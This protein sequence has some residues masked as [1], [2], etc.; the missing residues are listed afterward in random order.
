MTSCKSSRTIL[1]LTNT[2]VPSVNNTSI[3]LLDRS[4]SVMNRK[5]KILGKYIGDDMHTNGLTEQH[6]ITFKDSDEVANYLQ[7]VYL[8]KEEKKTT[9]LNLNLSRL[10]IA[11]TYSTMLSKALRHLDFKALNYLNLSNNCLSGKAL[12]EISR[13][14]PE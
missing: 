3:N 5:S 2:Y 14:L 6:K 9:K 13:N 7:K 1:N 4:S 11:K 10:H 12:E 8:T